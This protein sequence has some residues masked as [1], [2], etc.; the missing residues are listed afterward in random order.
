MMLGVGP[1]CRGVKVCTGSTGGTISNTAEEN[2]RSLLARL[3]QRGHY[4]NVRTYSI[5]SDV[6]N[7]NFAMLYLV[8]RCLG[9]ADTHNADAVMD[10]K[11][12]R[13][14]LDANYNLDRDDIL[15]IQ[16]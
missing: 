6:Y 15:G 14:D 12:R 7:L 4:S 13:F 3:S 10:S 8:S 1:T 16:V 11:R 2:V 9:L 5:Y